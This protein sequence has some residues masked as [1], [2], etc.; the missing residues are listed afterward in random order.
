[1]CAAAIGGTTVVGAA[2]M[3]TVGDADASAEPQFAQAPPPAM[4]TGATSTVA[5][6]TALT[7]TMATPTVLA[8]YSGESEP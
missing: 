7:T 3:G 2:V 5:I 8:T 1:M 6:A 4:S